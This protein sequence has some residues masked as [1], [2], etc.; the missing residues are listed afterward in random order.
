MTTHLEL[1]SAV[2]PGF[3]ATLPRFQATKAGASLLSMIYSSM[4]G[5]IIVDAAHRIVLVNQRAEHLF[6]YAAHALLEQPLEILILPRGRS[7]ESRRRMDRLTTGKAGGRRIQ[8]GLKGMHSDGTSMTLDA[9]ISRIMMHGELFLALVLRETKHHPKGPIDDRQHMPR[10]AEL[11][12]RAASS[13]HAN[14][15]EKRHFSKKLYDDIGQRLSV[16]KLDLDWLENSLAAPDESFPAR[17]AQMQ[18]LLDNVITIT[19]TMAS[20]LRPPLLDDFGLLAAV[21]WMAANFQK[22]TAV[23]CTVESNGIT[24]ELDDTIESA[25]FRVI[26]EAL[27]N[28][29]KHARAGNATISL[30]HIDGRLDVMIRDDGIGMTP[31]SDNKPGCYGLI[32]MQERIYVLGGTIG[33]ENSKPH[34]VTINVSVPIETTP[35]PEPLPSSPITR[36]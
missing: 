29:E 3:S 21:E 15:V 25:I 9:K 23:I 36:L 8:R 34:G 26:Q 4:D 30:M 2:P 31:G 24:V 22:K 35:H 10:M 19:K 12:R 28:I 16:L 5:V 1:D 18:G 17:V 6:G 11:R 7:S 13:Q 27:T 32:A 20:A 33:I 14:E